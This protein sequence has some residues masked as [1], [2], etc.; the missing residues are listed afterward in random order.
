M[1][2]FQDAPRLSNL[3]LQDPFFKACI[4]H[5]V[6]ALAK[7][8]KELEELGALCASVLMDWQTQ[9]ESCPPAHQPFDVFGN[10]IDRIEE[11][12]HWADYKAFAA[13][14]NL[15]GRGNDAALGAQNRLVQL[16]YLHL[17]SASSATYLCPLAMSD[18]AVSVL[19]EHAPQ[20]L[21]DRLIPRLVATDPNQAIT[22]G[23]W[24]TEKTGGSDV[25]GTQTCATL[26]Q[27]VGDEAQYVVNGIKWFTSATTSEMAL[28]LAQ[29]QGGLTLMCWEREPTDHGGIKG[30]NVL[31]LKEKLGTRALPTAELQLIDLKATRI[32]QEGRGVAT[33]SGMLNVTRYYNAI[34]SAS[35]M[36]LGS[37]LAED[38]AERRMSFGQKISAHPAMQYVLRTLKAQSHAATLMCFEL[39]ELLGKKEAATA[40]ASEL[41]Q[42]RVLVPLSKLLLGKQATA[43]AS[44]V[45][46]CFGGTGYL[47]QSGLP[48][49]LRD[50]QVFSI[51]EGTTNVL[52]LDMLRVELKS[53]AWSHYLEHLEHR[54]RRLD[55]TDL[56]PKL[57]GLRAL[58]GEATPKS[59][60]I[61]QLALAT[62]Y[63][64]QV[65]CMFAFAQA[66]G[67]AS[68]AELAQHFMRVCSASPLDA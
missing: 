41:H 30:V 58:V 11:A 35:S 2:F 4:G 33:I 13:K 51:W 10:R 9:A 26:E 48:R 56:V 62:G 7:S 16:P 36:A 57:E 5:F 64:T 20:S 52:A 25:S 3:Y 6:P 34:A 42:L 44:E 27:T 1:T 45:V 53:K 23:Q 18:A 19:Q 37:L 8:E 43:H 67:C 32:G 21:K 54:A 12:K 49:L 50:A 22:S 63:L 61:R 46:E 66:T 47:E 24:M 14:W 59:N 29:T 55:L 40:S 15:V 39:A 17:F 65:V 28:L 38:Y 60:C 31:R 68:D